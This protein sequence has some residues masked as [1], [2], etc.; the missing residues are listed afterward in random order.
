MEMMHMNTGDS[1]Q[2]VHHCIELWGHMWRGFVGSQHRGSD[3]KPGEKFPFWLCFGYC[4][5]TCTLSVRPHRLLVVI[6]YEFV[7]RG[8][9]VAA[10]RVLS[11][12]DQV[13][14]GQQMEEQWVE[15]GVVAVSA[16]SGSA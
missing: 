8:H 10:V 3:V 1:S 6:S 16:T 14:L 2:V 11:G 9:I 4:F 12:S 7:G 5:G 13:L 15:G